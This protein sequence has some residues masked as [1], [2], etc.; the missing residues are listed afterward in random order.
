[1]LRHSWAIISLIN[2]KLEN[3]QILWCDVVTEGEEWKLNFWDPVVPIQRKP[4]FNATSSSDISR[5]H[6]TA[7][8]S[9]LRGLWCEFCK[10]TQKH[11]RLVAW[12]TQSQFSSFWDYHTLEH[13]GPAY[14]LQFQ[15]IQYSMLRTKTRATRTNC[16]W[17]QPFV[18][19]VLQLQKIP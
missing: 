16:R 6:D 8:G 9:L 2:L 15:L 14:K 13:N 12:C 19:Q 10:G 17:R 7:V 18:A 3:S 11:V 5:L 1:M 4:T